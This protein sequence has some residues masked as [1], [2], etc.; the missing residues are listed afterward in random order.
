MKLACGFPERQRVISVDVPQ[1][2]LNSLFFG[3][4]HLRKFEVFGKYWIPLSHLPL[5]QLKYKLFSLNLYTVSKCS[6]LN[7]QKRNIKSLDL[8]WHYLYNVKTQLWR[9]LYRALYFQIKHG[10]RPHY[11]AAPW[12]TYMQLQA[13]IIIESLSRDSYTYPGYYRHALLNTYYIQIHVT[14]FHFISNI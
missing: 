9:H 10:S 2:A 12:S 6:M 5:S 4:E 14:M 11:P 8:L 13:N 3:R 7:L 1:A